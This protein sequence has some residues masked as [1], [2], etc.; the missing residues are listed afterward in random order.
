[1]QSL[2][3][4]LRAVAES[5]NTIGAVQAA[6]EKRKAGLQ[7]NLGELETRLRHVEQKSAPVR[8]RAAALDEQ[9]QGMRSQS[10]KA[11]AQRDKVSAELQALA[12]K[13]GADPARLEALQRERD[14]LHAQVQTLGIN[15]RPL[16][17]ELAKS[18]KEVE[19]FD[20]VV[21]KLSAER[22]AVATALARTE[23]HAQV[24]S[25]SAHGALRQALL[26]LARAGQEHGLTS[27]T[28]REAEAATASAEAAHGKRREE[29]V[30]RAALTSY[31]PRVYQQ[32]A[33]VMLGSSLALFFG[34]LLM[35]FL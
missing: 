35:I 29:E 15:A 16:E 3:R 9:L 34:L 17:D 32:G 22:S 6:G 10:R 14:Q 28:P 25:G 8:G 21:T 1:L 11:A 27:L 7:A 4:Q 2:V 5:A 33:Y 13:Q 24:E 18:S 12:A 19:K 23:R 31:D 30:H 26:S 20:A